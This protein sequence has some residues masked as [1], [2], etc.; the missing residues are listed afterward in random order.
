MFKAMLTPE[1]SVDLVKHW[2]NP[3]LKFLRAEIQND[4]DHPLNPL[5]NLFYESVDHP[6][7][8][9]RQICLP[10]PSVVEMLRF[11]MTTVNN[12]REL[13]DTDKDSHWN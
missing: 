1:A 10:I 3:K 2:E 9:P 8:T 4:V 13:T 11:A 6:G 7:K 12:A 5:L